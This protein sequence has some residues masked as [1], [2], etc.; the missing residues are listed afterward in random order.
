[1]NYVRKKLEIGGESN[2]SRLERKVSCGQAKPHSKTGRILK[3]RKCNK[4]SIDL[5]E[6]EQGLS[7]SVKHPRIQSI[8]FCRLDLFIAVS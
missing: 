8:S 2:D 6:V 7:S 1:M 3:L 4:A 5:I